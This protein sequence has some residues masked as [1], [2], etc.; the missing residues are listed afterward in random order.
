[1]SAI[2]SIIINNYNYGHFLRDAIESVLK[3][4]YSSVELIVV[5]DGSTD[6]SLTIIH[7]YRHHCIAIAQ[8][9][10]GQAAALN[11]GFAQATGDVI[12]FLDAD[13]QLH[14]QAAAMVAQTWEHHP[15]LARMNYRMEVI[16]HNGKST[17]MIKPALH[18]PM[19]NGNLRNQVLHFADDMG[20]LPT[21][22]NAYNA[23]VL[24]KIFP[25]P[26]QDFP[27]LADCYL[28]HL[29]PLFGDVIAI[30][31]VCASYRMHGHNNHEQGYVNMAQLRRSMVHWQASHRAIHHF[32]APLGLN[33]TNLGSVTFAAHRLLSLRLAPALHPFSNDSLGKA[34]SAG[35]RAS[36]QRFDLRIPLRLL[37]L[38]WFVCVAIAPKKLVYWLAQQFL[39]PETRIPI[40]ALLQH[41]HR[42]RHHNQTQDG[43]AAFSQKY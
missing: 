14:P 1:M 17:G 42:R 41:F 12:I 2:V 3:Q 34:L 39:F 22:G 32:A 28:N 25:I 24:R 20:W 23:A 27:I 7:D 40:N 26:E 31:D 13:D 11:A 33:S 15:N 36:L 16:D 21:S 10:K 9:H 5:D 29:T 35:W 43:L 4:T 38:C 8:E 30:E 6:D 37:L 18:V 19:P